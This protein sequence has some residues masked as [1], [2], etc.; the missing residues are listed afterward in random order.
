MGFLIN[1]A[2]AL[3]EEQV[4]KIDDWGVFIMVFGIPLLAVTLTAIWKMITKK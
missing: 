4:S 2:H 1:S 3:T